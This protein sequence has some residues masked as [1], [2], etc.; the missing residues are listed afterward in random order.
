M[1]LK[2]TDIHFVLGFEPRAINKHSRQVLSILHGT[3]SR[4][5][6][7]CVNMQACMH[8]NLYQHLH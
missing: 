8:T 5:S 2:H 4:A 7:I 3:S 1:N 6:C